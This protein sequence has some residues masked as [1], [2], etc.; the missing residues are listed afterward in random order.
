MKLPAFG[1]LTAIKISISRLDTLEP[2]SQGTLN[3]EVVSALA[4][5]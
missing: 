4:K 1:L 5:V 2:K 3:K